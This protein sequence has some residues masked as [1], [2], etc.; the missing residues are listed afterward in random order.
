MIFFVVIL[1]EVIQF[2][3]CIHA[4]SKDGCFVRRCWK[5][6]EKLSKFDIF[7][8]VIDVVVK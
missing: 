7:P 5:E 1:V 3:S 2:I 4:E 6:Y 8:L